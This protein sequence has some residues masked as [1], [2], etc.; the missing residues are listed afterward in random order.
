MTPVFS[1]S[2]I[3]EKIN[4]KGKTTLGK[5]SRYFSDIDLTSILNKYNKSTYNKKKYECLNINDFYN[6]NNISK[7]NRI[8]NGKIYTSI[9]K[10]IKN[11]NIHK[12]K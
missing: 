1:S 4:S 6:Y 12:I 11:K 10:K 5:C 3:E 2:L 8:S 9:K 7:N